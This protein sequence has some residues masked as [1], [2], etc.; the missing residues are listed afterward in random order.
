MEPESKRLRLMV[1]YGYN[2][3]WEKRGE[4]PPS[5]SLIDI[6]PDFYAYA[7]K[8]NGDYMNEYVHIRDVELIDCEYIEQEVED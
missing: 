6:D 4:K 7:N 3:F 1:M 2:K 8:Y 5:V